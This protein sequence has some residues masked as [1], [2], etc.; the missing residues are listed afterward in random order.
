MIYF[1]VTLPF[2][3]YTNCNSIINID[4]KVTTVEEVLKAVYER[5]PKLKPFIEERVYTKQKSIRKTLNG[6]LL[7][8]KKI[9]S[10]KAAVQ[11]GDI[12]LLKPLTNT[13]VNV[14]LNVIKLP[15]IDHKHYYHFFLG[16][17]FPIL[18]WYLKTKDDP[19]LGTIY[20]RSCSYLDKILKEVK[21]PRLKIL[22]REKFDAELNKLTV[23]AKNS[24]TI[25]N[26]IR[27][28]DMNRD[29]D[30]KKLAILYPASGI[31]YICEFL[32]KRLQ[33]KIKKESKTLPEGNYVLV[34]KRGDPNKSNKCDEKLVAGSLRRS[35]SNFDKM[36]KLI[37]KVGFKVFPVEL[38]D[39]SFAWQI[40]AFSRANMVVA[41]HGAG[42]TNIV[43]SPPGMSVVEI[44]PKEM[45]KVKTL[46]V[47]VIFE[48]LTR[49]LDFGHKLVVQSKRH[50]PVDTKKV[51]DALKKLSKK[52]NQYAK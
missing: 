44:M 15:N 23:T 46:L 26:N 7:N 41:Q 1:K 52:K 35:I 18:F 27:G 39:K 28:W 34:I 13:K 12:F 30:A 10:L 8:N 43:F 2:T 37:E 22:E 19:S 4:T 36:V 48:S 3:A 20:V 32:R 40:A 6:L 25:K 38:E 50:G 24:K 16:Y 33:N 17:F 45:V 51:I 11:D 5:F 14:M 42:L 47:K 9:T 49:D 29:K 21:I 31:R